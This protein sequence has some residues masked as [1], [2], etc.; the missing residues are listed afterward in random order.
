MLLSKATERDLANLQKIAET[1]NALIE[2][3]NKNG[4]LLA[5]STSIKALTDLR[6]KE[7]KPLYKVESFKK[8]NYDHIEEIITYD[9]NLEI[10]KGKKYIKY[11]FQEKFNKQENYWLNLANKWLNSNQEI[12]NKNSIINKLNF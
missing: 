2:M 6:S 11:K 12:K 7:D 3:R 4:L 8:L 1:Q 10:Y 9:I 5:V